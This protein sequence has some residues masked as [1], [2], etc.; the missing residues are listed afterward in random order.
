MKKLENLSLKN[1]DVFFHLDTSKSVLLT[2]PIYSMKGS[3]IFIYYNKFM[4][5]LGGYFVCLLLVN[6]PF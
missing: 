3:D 1:L 6:T 2:L 4:E 5:N